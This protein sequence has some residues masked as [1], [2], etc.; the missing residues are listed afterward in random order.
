MKDGRFEVLYAED[1]E[2]DVLF[3]RRALEA[4]CA[5]VS[6]TVAHDGEEAIRL[7]SD[8]WRPD[9]LVLD[10]K[11]PRRSGLDVLKWVRGQEALKDLP[12]T[13]LSSS[14]EQSDMARVQELGIVEYIVKP[15][16]YEGLMSVI[17]RLCSRWGVA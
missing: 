6:L 17:R 3:M 14:A 15:V 13:V 11:M 16:N 4:S 7:L 10:L 5:S 12:V 2:D 8:D 1:E 9:W